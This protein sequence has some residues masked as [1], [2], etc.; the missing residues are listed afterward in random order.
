[1]V[2]IVPP[3]DTAG[4]GGTPEPAWYGN[5]PDV[6]GYL[7]NRGLHDKP[8]P[9]V[10]LA[11]IKAHQEAQKFIGI[12]ASQLLRLPTEA[13]DEAG[14]KSVW[15]RLG[16]PDS[17]DGYDLSGVKSASGDPISPA[18]ADAIR[19]AAV[20]AHL[21]K[22]AAPALAAAVQKTLDAQAEEAATVGAAALETARAALKTNWGA[23]YEGN[24]FVAK[25]AAAA[26]GVTAEVVNALE[27]QVGY[28]KVMEMFRTIGSKIGED[29]FVSNANPNLPGVKTREQAIVERKELMAD[30]GFAK[31][32]LEG[33]AQERRQMDA[34]SVLIAGPE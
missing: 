33:G 12:P 32:Y 29:K 15:G 10:A 22:D 30:P 28:D 6:V 11:A 5:D 8:P 7:Q 34:L 4:T 17:A 3:A 13:S 16:A 9:E 2:D 23:N 14:W 27:S 25:Q 31:R 24:M 21:P 18:L 1:M 20:S 19:A 26:L